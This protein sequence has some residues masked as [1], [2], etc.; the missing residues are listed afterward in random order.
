MGIALGADQA[1]DQS[2]PGRIAV[3][4]NLRGSEPV[5]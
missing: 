3:D 1:V 5:A 4:V 2:G